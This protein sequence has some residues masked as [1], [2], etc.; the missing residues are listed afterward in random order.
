MWNSLSFVL[1]VL[2]LFVSVGIP[3]S[4]L[5][6][7]ASI[8]GC[9]EGNFAFTYLSVLVGANI[10][11]KKHWKLI[12]DKFK[13]NLPTYFLSLFKAPQGVLKSLEKIRRLFLQKLKIHLVDWKKVI[14]AKKDDGL[15]MG[16]LKTQ[17]IA[18]LMKWWWRLYNC[19]NRLWKNEILIIHNLRRKP[20]SYIAQKSSNGL[21]SNI[22][23][24]I[25]NLDSIGINYKDYF[26]LI[27]GSSVNI[28]FWKD[29]WCA[30]ITF[31]SPFPTLCNLEERKC[32]LIHERIFA[33]GFSWRWK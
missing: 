20:V 31:E 19:A 29:I 33:N 27:S 15:G 11:L 5:H 10:A 7:M 8:L 22:Y 32:F 1:T 2:V 18:L 23:K 26:R 24:E 3:K 25:N 17:S 30:N 14:A 28:L 12:V 21:W 13:S 16:T 4:E 6:H 9:C